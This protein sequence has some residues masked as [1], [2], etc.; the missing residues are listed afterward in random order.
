MMKH[1]KFMFT[2]QGN[3]GDSERQKYALRHR[4]CYEQETV[5]TGEV[6]WRQAGWA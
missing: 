6:G 3:M 5:S 4:C 1:V 2:F